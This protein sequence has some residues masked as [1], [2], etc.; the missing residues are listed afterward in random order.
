MSGGMRAWKSQIQMAV[1]ADRGCL[2][3]LAGAQQRPAIALGGPFE[4][5]DAGAF[6]RAVTERL[7]LR[8]AAAAPPVGLACDQFD[9]PRLATA[10]LGSFRH[11]LPPGSDVL[12]CRR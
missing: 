10:D 4:G 5:L 1:V 2:R 6:V 7:R 8:A 9:Q 11:A 3:L 12:S